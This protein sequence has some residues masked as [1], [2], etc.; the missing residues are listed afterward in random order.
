MTVSRIG[1]RNCAIT[2]DLRT[3]RPSV[4]AVPV[5]V[6]AV[7]VSGTIRLG[8]YKVMAGHSVRGSRRARM[9]LATV[10]RQVIDR[11]KS[12][13]PRASAASTG[14]NHSFSP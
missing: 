14:L 9:A 7:P 4:G 3:P 1:I 13:A 12:R 8:H 6:S 10:R 2:K 11:T 5:A